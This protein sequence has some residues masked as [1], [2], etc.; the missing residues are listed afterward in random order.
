MKTRQLGKTDLELPILGFGASSLGQEFRVVTIDD[1][2]KSVRVA[3]DLQRVLAQQVRRAGLVD[4]GGRRLRIA[5]SLAEPDQARV[6]VQLD[7][8]QV[9][10]LG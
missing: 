2:L 6:G 8:D 7:P 4:V 10:V 5:K 9:A 1:A 3:L